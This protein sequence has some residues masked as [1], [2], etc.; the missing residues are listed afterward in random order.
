[1]K[2]MQQ[3][4]T[5]IELMIVVAII[6]ILAAIALPAY[7]DYTIRSK[8][9]ELLVFAAAGKTSVAEFY[10]SQGHMPLNASSAGISTTANPTKYISTQNYVQTSTNVG[11]ITVA[12]NTTNLGT[13]GNLIFVGTVNATTGII[14][15]ACTTSTIP[16]KYL[17]ANCR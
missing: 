7:Q 6:G 1:M 17:P 4:F 15:W 5:L 10:Q 16:S 12:A 3:G 13:T 8:V 2:T 11:T 9:T 14:N